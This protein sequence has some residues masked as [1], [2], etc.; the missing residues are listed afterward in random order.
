MNADEGRSYLGE[1]ITVPLEDGLSIQATI[2]YGDDS[3]V[4]RML[5][6][7][8]PNPILGGDSENNVV[9]ALLEAAVREGG[10]GMTFDYRGVAEG[11]VGDTDLL[12]Y[13][14]ELERAGD[15]DRIVEDSMRAIAA[16]QRE[17]GGVARPSLVGY[18]FGTLIALRCAE[19]LALSTVG[20]VSPP[21]LECDFAPLL[22]A[23]K[24][25]H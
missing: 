4:G 5:V 23:F 9:Q 21:I 24:T 20:G 12:T 10:L 15:Y 22:D 3:D 18:S 14:E 19:K 25:V 8:P 16:A 17:F 7:C 2:A 11:R 1:T 6:V 13:W